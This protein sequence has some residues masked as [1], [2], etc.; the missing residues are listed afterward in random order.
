MNPLP[1]TPHLLDSLG[2]VVDARLGPGHPDRA[3]VIKLCAEAIGFSWVLSRRLPEG[4][5]GMRAR[6][7]ASL[8]LEL[9]L[10]ELRAGERHRLAVACEI[11]AT[12]AKVDL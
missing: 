1:T 10:P 6:A 7:A 11:L 3:Y 12:G 5:V 2:A 9:G 4:H 8:M